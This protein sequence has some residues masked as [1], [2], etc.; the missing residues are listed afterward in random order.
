MPTVQRTIEVDATPSVALAT[1]EHFVRWVMS[2][3]QR[4]VCD[5]FAC[6]DAV[7]AGL[8]SFAPVDGG[9]RT[10]VTFRL[11]SDEEGA[12]P[13]AALEQNVVRDLVVFKDYI[14]GAGNQVGVPTTSEK[15]AMR[16]DEER[17]THAQAHRS[18]HVE[19]ASVPNRNSFPT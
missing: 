4:L 7:R 6:V 16:A 10:A 5:E 15:Q 13:Q 1:W 14:E 11:E 9:A 18:V 2:G 12:P 19:D 3:H 17:R 8:V